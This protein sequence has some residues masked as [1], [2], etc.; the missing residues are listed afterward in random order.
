M[1]YMYVEAI[2]PPSILIGT[3]RVDALIY[4]M[5]CNKTKVFEKLK[6]NYTY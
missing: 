1:I 3:K 5:Y 4:L 2:T 6:R